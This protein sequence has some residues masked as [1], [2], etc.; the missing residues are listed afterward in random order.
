MLRCSG[1][2]YTLIIKCLCD[3]DK[4]LRPSGTRCGPAADPAEE[5]HVHHAWQ[6]WIAPLRFE[7]ACEVLEEGGA[8]RLDA[9]P[10]CGPGTQV[11]QELRAAPRHRQAK[12][13]WRNL[14]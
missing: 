5:F 7:R 2:Q 8:V 12:L 14:V 3:R 6:R 9:P 13:R 4:T 1:G 11:R 10:G